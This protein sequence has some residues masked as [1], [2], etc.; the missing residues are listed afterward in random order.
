MY[1]HLPE[2]INCDQTY[3]WRDEETN[4][5]RQKSLGAGIM[6]TDFVDE[7]GGFVR[8]QTKEARSS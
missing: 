6:V 8:T 1:E 5:L 4:V 3:F 2:R 7:V